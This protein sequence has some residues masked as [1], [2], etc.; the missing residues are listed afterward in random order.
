MYKKKSFLAIIPARK[1]SKRI[2]DKNLLKINNKTLVEIAI[3]E[4]LKSKYIDKII[5]SS[6]S[7][8]INKISSKF[9]CVPLKESPKSL[10]KD[11]SKTID[12][13]KFY[14]NLYT[15]FDY[16]LVLQPTSPFRR[17]TQID[18]SIENVI[19]KKLGS[20]ISIE[21]LNYPK[22]WINKKDEFHKF[23]KLNNQY[24]RNEYFKPNG[25]IFIINSSLL[26]SK[27]L[28]GFYSRNTFYFEMDKI[29]SI[30]IDELSDYIIAKGLEKKIIV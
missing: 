12:L 30:D 3:L 28:K 15:Q 11:N 13:I 9:N 2:K 14:Y 23:V 10:S 25:S 16:I 26:K 6:D 18:Q 20:L 21:K 7:P 1:N 22:S 19:N 5:V 4:S 24:D 17:V 29:S 27:K 8:R